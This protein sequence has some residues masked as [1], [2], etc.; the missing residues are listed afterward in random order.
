M[1][2]YL[3][4]DELDSTNTY[5]KKHHASLPDKTVIAADT[6]TAGRGRCDR[7][8]CSGKGGLYFSVLLK[9]HKTDF[10]S[11]VTQL[12]ALS[13]CRALEDLR[14]P[15]YLKWPNDV[16]ADG[17][18][19]CGILSETVAFGGRIDALAV[20][21]GVN[22]SQDGLERVGQPAVSLRELGVLTD[23][24][25]LLAA[26]LDYFWR[27]YDALLQRGFEAIR[28][29]YKARFPYLGKQ[30]AVKNG[31][32]TLFGTVQDVSPGGTLVLRTAK[33]TENIYIG[34]MTL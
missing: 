26:I 31:G 32:Q 16:L 5:A 11:N 10:L 3:H 2:R 15:A 17:K 22:V 19:I 24:E 33:G 18:K 25:T 1:E 7:K 6:Q 27:D 29:P 8:W 23:K 34:D 9:P 12:M 28:T 21:T 30:T 4:F 14:V 13:V 20:G